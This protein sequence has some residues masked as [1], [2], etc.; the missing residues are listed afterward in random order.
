M[1]TINTSSEPI[2]QA[3]ESLGPGETAEVH[4][5]DRSHRS[6]SSPTFTQ[7]PPLTKH[8]YPTRHRAVPASTNAGAKARASNAQ[9][10][11]QDTSAAKLH[12]SKA[13]EEAA[14]A[15]RVNVLRDELARLENMR[16][17]QDA[18]EQAN[19]GMLDRKSVV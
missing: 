5:P 9:A 7:V 4:G 8:R 2:A 18:V 19:F 1:D 16:A 14:Y 3:I 15:N 6:G 11:K 10:A 13:A 12:A 17:E